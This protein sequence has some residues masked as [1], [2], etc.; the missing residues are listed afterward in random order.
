MKSYIGGLKRIKINLQ[1]DD[2]YRELPSGEI[3]IQ[4]AAFVAGKHLSADVASIN[5][6]K[7][8]KTKRIPSDGVI[9]FITGKVK[10]IC[11]ENHNGIIDHDINVIHDANPFN[12]AHALI[13][14]NPKQNLEELVGPSRS[15]KAQRQLRQCLKDIVNENNGLRIKPSSNE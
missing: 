12:K 13:I 1:K 8:E 11:I 10:D 3:I 6:F 2:H 9:G 5:C 4:S 7:P 15:K 14:M